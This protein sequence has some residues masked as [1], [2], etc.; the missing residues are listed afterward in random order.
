MHVHQENVVSLSDS[1]QIRKEHPIKVS[2][3]SPRKYEPCPYL[4]ELLNQ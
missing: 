1:V 3:V 2:G 4:G